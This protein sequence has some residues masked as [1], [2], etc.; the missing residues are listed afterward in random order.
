[1]GVNIPT[2][3]YLRVFI[4]EIGSCNHYFNGGG[5]PGFTI[6][7]QNQPTLRIMGSQKWWFGDPRPLLYTSKPLYSKVQWF[8][9]YTDLWTCFR[10]AS[11]PRSTPQNE[12]VLQGLRIKKKRRGFTRKKSLGFAKTPILGPPCGFVSPKKIKNGVGS[13]S[14]NKNNNKTTG[15]CCLLFFFVVGRWGVYLGL[16]LRGWVRSLLF[17]KGE[18]ILRDPITPE[19]LITWNIMEP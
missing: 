13:S 11:L 14:S 15:G 2:I 19:W 4:I 9:G 8:L 3:V 7:H 12:D 5:S 16:N 10:A 18:R 1:M 17:D 6:C